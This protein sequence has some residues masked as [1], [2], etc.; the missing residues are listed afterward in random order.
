MTRISKLLAAV[1][2]ANFLA[3]SA[4]MAFENP[5][6][7]YDRP[8]NNMNVWHRSP[9][10]VNDLCRRLVTHPDNPYRLAANGG[11][12]FEACAIGGPAQC[13]LVMPQRA[14]ITRASYD[15]LYRHE[16][17]HCNGWNH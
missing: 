3:G 7:E 13:I 10:K 12:V 6:P 2:M 8:A 17:A 4:A 5:P 1:T 15:R 14:S 16:R 11:G 9:V